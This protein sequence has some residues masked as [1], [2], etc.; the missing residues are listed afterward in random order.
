M[1]EDPNVVYNPEIRRAPFSRETSAEMSLK[2]C[3][4]PPP[5]ISRFLHSVFTRSADGL[6]GKFRF[7]N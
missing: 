5:E 6:W 1:V 2:E 3:L 4:R 7:C